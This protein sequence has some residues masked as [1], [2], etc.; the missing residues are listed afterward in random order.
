MKIVFYKQGKKYTLNN[1]TISDYD[2]YFNQTFL[3]TA[4]QALEDQVDEEDE[5]IMDEIQDGIHWSNVSVN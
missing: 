1:A 3:I 4:T 2:G 5:Y